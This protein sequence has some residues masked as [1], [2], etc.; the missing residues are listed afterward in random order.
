MTFDKKDFQVRLGSVVTDKGLLHINPTTYSTAD[1]GW[2]LYNEL[3]DKAHS[4]LNQGC[5]MHLS[6][7]DDGARRCFAYCWQQRSVCDWL[8]KYLD[9]HSA[10]KKVAASKHKHMMD[11]LEEAL[12]ALCEDKNTG[13][14]RSHCPKSTYEKYSKKFDH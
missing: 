5:S 2:K 8:F 11:V 9:P 7:K 4:E 10:S 13:K 6:G 14:P 1:D 12:G 3:K